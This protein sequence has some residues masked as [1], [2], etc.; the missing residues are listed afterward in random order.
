MTFQ[1]RTLRLSVVTD[2]GRYGRTIQ[3]VSGL[4]VIRAENSTGKS[5]C[6]QSVIY[7]LGLEAML[8]ARHTIPLKHA[9]HE[10][11]IGPDGEQHNVL[12]SDVW[13]ELENGS[14]EQL[15]VRRTVKGE[16]NSHLITVWSS[17]V[18]ST[19]GAGATSRDYFV[20][21]SGS[22]TRSRG[23]HRF[24]VEF[25]EWELPDVTK[26][27]GTTCPLYVENLF[28]AVIVEQT[29]GWSGIQAAMP[30]HFQIRNARQR[31][32]EFLLGLEA[33]E[34]L[35][36]RQQIQADKT[37][38]RRRWSE[39]VE[40]IQAIALSA[41]TTVQGL[42]MQPVTIW[43]PEAAMQFFRQAEHAPR[44]LS[45]FIHELESELDSAAA[46]P[47]PTGAESAGELEAGLAAHS[48]RLSEIG[49][50]VTEFESE[51]AQNR[52]DQRAVERRLAALDEDLA[53]HRDLSR[54]RQ[55]GS[56][57]DL[58]IAR[59]RCPACEQPLADTLMPQASSF[60]PIELDDTIQL[61]REEHRTF[62]AMREQ[63][64]GR[65]V[66]LAQRL[67]ALG[68][69]SARV[70]TEIRAARATLASDGR[71]PSEAAITHRVEIRAELTR[72]SATR[73]RLDAHLF[74]L[75]DLA[76]E[77]RATL[78]REASL[79]DGALSETDRETLSQFAES[80][81]SQLAE[82]GLKSLDPA[83]FAISYETY[84][85]TYDQFDLSFDLSAS[86]A[87]RMVWA[88]LVALLEVARS[89]CGNHPGLLLFDE[90]QQQKIKDVSFRELLRRVASA[91]DH[92]QQVILV[93]SEREE[94]LREMLDGVPAHLQSME[95]WL[96]QPVPDDA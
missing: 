5:T 94:R 20:R 60:Q 75:G 22:A 18:L 32:I 43:P 9:M 62:G 52:L 36:R 91:A 45:E 79:P 51:L 66:V 77:W 29:R 7:A 23:F 92:G 17:F 26:Y 6:V 46:T 28:A 73:Q 83:S 81:R 40:T 19:A 72:V 85:P 50:A 31:A 49:L 15:T 47:I 55:M 89:A 3:F 58:A 88:Y 57:E 82:Y 90:P 87:I 95:G 8:T 44:P 70:M 64:G 33:Y 35:R 38:L 78:A 34:V 39:R 48:E 12:E 96:L 76:A 14:G 42:P 74:A 4:N 54:L 24:L 21:Q 13:L 37:G 53:H 59:G 41:Q 56:V 69:E 93:T 30:L 25:L 71:Q 68:Q 2:A 67:S 61:I 10:Y 63:L 11:L 1:L 65:S 27:D 16:R 80:F 84:H 86:D